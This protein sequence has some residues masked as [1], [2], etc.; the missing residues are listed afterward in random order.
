MG[1]DRPLGLVQ[2]SRGSQPG[3]A[4]SAIRCERPSGSVGLSGSCVGPYFHFPPSPGSRIVGGRHHAEAAVWA[5]AIVVGDPGRDDDGQRPLGV[6]DCGEQGVQSPATC[7]A[8]CSSPVSAGRTARCCARSY[9]RRAI[10]WQGLCGAIHPRTAPTSGGCSTRSSSWKRTFWIRILSFG[11]SSSHNQTRSTTSP[12]R[13]L[14]LARGIS[15][16]SR[17]TFQ[18]SG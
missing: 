6:V 14:C 3:F 13:H 5:L 11:R 1:G 9:S 15:P 12:R 8:A 18:Q 7:R 10:G 16:C 4:Q 2:F 17:R